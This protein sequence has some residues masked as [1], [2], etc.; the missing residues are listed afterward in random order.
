MAKNIKKAYKKVAKIQQ[1]NVQKVAKIL[2]TYLVY[3]N[4]IIIGGYEK[5]IDYLKKIIKLE[6]IRNEKAINGNSE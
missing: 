6:R 5:W 4:N 3:D 2:T 1:K